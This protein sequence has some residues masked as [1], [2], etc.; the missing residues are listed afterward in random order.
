MG[1]CPTVIQLIR[2][3]YFGTYAT[4]PATREMSV[5]EQRQ[6]G[7]GLDRFRGQVAGWRRKVEDWNP[8]V[9]YVSGTAPEAGGQTNA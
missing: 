8:H 5:T 6:T 2:Y 7:L 4:L 9:H 3:G 1:C